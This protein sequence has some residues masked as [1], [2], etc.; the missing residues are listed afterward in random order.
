M[1]LLL[2]PMDTFSLAHLMAGRIGAWIAESKLIIAIVL[3]SQ[4]IQSSP[5]KAYFHP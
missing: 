1:D 4:K 5:S 2:L 3:N